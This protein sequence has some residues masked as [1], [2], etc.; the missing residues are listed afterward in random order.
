MNQKIKF[1][2]IGYWLLVHEWLIHWYCHWPPKSHI[3]VVL[4]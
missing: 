3:S 4:Y 1:K 2:N